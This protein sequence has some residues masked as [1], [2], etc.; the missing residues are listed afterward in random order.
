[1]LPQAMLH[2]GAAVFQ[3]LRQLFELLLRNFWLYNCLDDIQQRIDSEPLDQT[4]NGKRWLFVFQAGTLFR[5]EEQPMV[6]QHTQDNAT[7]QIL[8]RLAAR[9][10]CHNEG[11]AQP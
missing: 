11:F 7:A 5:M 3:R 8:Q 2:C 9:L 6:T 4:A 1:M 10:C